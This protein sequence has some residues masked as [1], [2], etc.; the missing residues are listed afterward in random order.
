VPL[1]EVTMMSSGLA[2]PARSSGVIAKIAA[3]AWQPVFATRV[4]AAMAGRWAG[5]SGSPY[6][7]GLLN[8]PP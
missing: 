6:V 7:H 5:S 1:I 4:A 8:A 3:T 2:R